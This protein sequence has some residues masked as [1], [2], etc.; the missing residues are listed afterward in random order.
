MKLT[1][2]WFVDNSGQDLF[3]QRP[4]YNDQDEKLLTMA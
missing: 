4:Q 1:F 2:D 3:G